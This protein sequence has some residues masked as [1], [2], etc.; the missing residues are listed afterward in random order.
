[1]QSETLKFILGTFLI[2]LFAGCKESATENPLKKLKLGVWVPAN[3]NVSEIHTRVPGDPPDIIQTFN[4][5][6]WIIENEHEMTAW[7]TIFFKHELTQHK[8]DKKWYIDF[9][10]C[11][12]KYDKD[13]LICIYTDAYDRKISIPYLHIMEKSAIPTIEQVMESIDSTTWS[14]TSLFSD[15]PDSFVFYVNLENRTVAHIQVL[16][17]QKEFNPKLNRNIDTYEQTI[18]YLHNNI[19]L[20]QFRNEIYA[21]KYINPQIDSIGLVSLNSID[22]RNI[23]EYVVLKKLKSR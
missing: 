14:N 15:I 2:L 19:Y 4:I 13:T 3:N 1:M 23:N 7:N 8:D 10:D 5:P 6:I 18:F 17:E 16:I 22:N 20:F 21:L 9:Y 12:I 11:Q